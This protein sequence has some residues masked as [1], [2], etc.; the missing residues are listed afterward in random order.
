LA[1]AKHRRPKHLD[2]DE[3]A[4]R[5]LRSTLFLFGDD[6]V[7]DLVIGGL[8]DDLLPDQV[9][10]RLVGTAVDDFLRVLL[11]DSRQRVQLFLAGGVE[12]Y[13]RRP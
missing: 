3:E 1:N 7:L 9:G 8:G 6:L 4:R 11:A 13:V 12:I 2:P 5:V 10:L